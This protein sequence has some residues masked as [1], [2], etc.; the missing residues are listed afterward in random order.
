MTPSEAETRLAQD[1]GHVRDE[2]TRMDATETHIDELI[3]EAQSAVNHS[4]ARPAVFL[5]VHDLPVDTADTVLVA[6]EVGVD[7][8]LHVD[9]PQE[10][11]R[12]PVRT[13]AIVPVSF[14]VCS[15]G[16]SCHVNHVTAGVRGQRYARHAQVQLGEAAARLQGTISL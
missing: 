15:Q 14:C 10:T 7:S 9:A 5:A 12:H 4:L 6:V 16:R 11:T 13:A 8:T 3:I 2:L 1:T